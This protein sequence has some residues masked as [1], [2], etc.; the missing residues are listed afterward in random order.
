MELTI[1]STYESDLQEA[2]RLGFNPSHVNTCVPLAFSRDFQD[3]PEQIDILG[4]KTPSIPGL[5]HK[6]P[7]YFAA[8][9]SFP[10]FAD[11]PKSRLTPISQEEMHRVIK[12]FLLYN[13]EE[14][15]PL[16]KSAPERE[17]LERSLETYPDTKPS[18]RTKGT[19]DWLANELAKQRGL[20]GSA[21]TPRPCSAST[22][23]GLC[24]RDFKNLL[25]SG[26]YGKNR[27]IR[28]NDPKYMEHVWWQPG[29]S[30]SKR[31]SSRRKSTRRKSSRKKTTHRK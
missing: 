14:W 30:K 11:V 18:Y 24:S 12:E 3:K 26:T 4:R 28:K 29:G 5:K 13:K 20:H 7:G 15:P 10:G 25:D 31:K 16:M 19:S 23:Y 9:P 2:I 1:P 21:R 8:H 6:V 22:P 27:L 17:I